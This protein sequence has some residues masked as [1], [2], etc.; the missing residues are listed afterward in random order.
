MMIIL[1][2]FLQKQSLKK[3]WMGGVRRRV[4]SKENEMN[5]VVPAPPRKYLSGS[6]AA[7][8]V[9]KSKIGLSGDPGA[10]EPR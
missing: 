9:Q 6:A 2:L 4:Y 3:S 8:V 7:V 10:T 1:L 5:E